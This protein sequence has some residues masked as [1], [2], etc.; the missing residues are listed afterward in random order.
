MR[1]I[2]SQGDAGRGAVAKFLTSGH[3]LAGEQRGGCPPPRCG[4]VYWSAGVR[5]KN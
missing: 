3:P 5:A 1:V 2:M 4:F